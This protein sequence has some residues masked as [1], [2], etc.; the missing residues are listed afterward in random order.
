MRPVT[1]VELAKQPHFLY[2]CYDDDGLLLYIGCSNDVK[3]RMV[4][5]RSSS[6]SRASLLLQH[7]M[8]SHEVDGDE[9]AG[10]LAGIAA[11]ARAIADEQPLFNMTGRRFPGFIT[12]NKI[13]R[14]LIAHGHVELACETTCTCWRETLDEGK[15]DPWCSAHV[16]Q[17]VLEI[18]PAGDVA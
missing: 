5:H 2:R 14:Y 13:A 6:R 15:C 7:F 12:T 4:T 16:A 1:A 9:Y 18:L 17:G 10:R 3:A 8:D 11:E